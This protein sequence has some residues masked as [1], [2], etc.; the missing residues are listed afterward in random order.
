M[1]GRWLW[2]LIYVYDLVVIPGLSSNT[3]PSLILY[4]G[5][6]HASWSHHQTASQMLLPTVLN[7]SRT[8]EQSQDPSFTSAVQKELN[9][10]ARIESWAMS[11]CVMFAFLIFFQ[12]LL[13]AYSLFSYSRILN[14]P[15]SRSENSSMSCLLL[16]ARTSIGNM[17]RWWADSLRPHVKVSQWQWAHEISVLDAHMK[18]NKSSSYVE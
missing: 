16:N 3:F 4:S 1:Q 18:T 5:P 17:L 14:Q 2:Q 11:M 12:H 9:G 6:L 10:G 15:G 7:M 13:W 8:P